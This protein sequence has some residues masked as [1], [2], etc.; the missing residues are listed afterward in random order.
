MKIIFARCGMEGVAIVKNNFKPPN[1]FVFK[2]IDYTQ[3][4]SLGN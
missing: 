2:F 3:S 4:L 1:L